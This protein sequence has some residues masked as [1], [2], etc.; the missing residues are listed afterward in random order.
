MSKETSYYK[1]WDPPMR[2]DR[3]S[4][5]AV[6]RGRVFLYHAIFIKS[7]KDK[8]L[9]A[10]AFELRILYSFLIILGLTIAVLAQSGVLDLFN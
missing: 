3:V 8:E 10:E 9:K 5:L 7:Y 2:G 6:I 1:E 4:T